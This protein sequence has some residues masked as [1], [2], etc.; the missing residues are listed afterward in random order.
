MRRV[1]G[2]PNLVRVHPDG[3]PNA[4]G[5]R[6]Q[7]AA[8]FRAL[9]PFIAALDGAVRRRGESRPAPVSAGR[10]ETL[11]GRTRNSGSTV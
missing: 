5:N 1:V 3:A 8:A 11:A 10:A 7:T 2:A 9:V 6:V 4:S